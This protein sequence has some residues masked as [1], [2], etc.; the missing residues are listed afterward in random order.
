MSRFACQNEWN[1][2]Q[3]G[4]LR[5]LWMTELSTAAI[6]KELRMTK[7]AVIGKAHRIGLPGRP[8]PIKRS[9]APRQ[10]LEKR[11]RNRAEVRGRRTTLAPI[12]SAEEMKSAIAEP[13]TIAGAH[14]RTMLLA[15]R[16][17]G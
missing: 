1:D 13:V 9:D 11:E 10:D 14:E 15:D 4:E 2:T 6:A 17:S 3:L 16:H 12:A 7:D 8:S 5:S